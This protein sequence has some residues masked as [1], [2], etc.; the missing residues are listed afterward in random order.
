MSTIAGNTKH[1]LR[2]VPPTYLQI[3]KSEVCLRKAPWGTHDPSLPEIPSLHIR[4]YI[5]TYTHIHIHVPVCLYDFS[6]SIISFLY[7][8]YIMNLSEPQMQS[9]RPH[10]LW[11]RFR[12]QVRM[13]G[14]GLASSWVPCLDLVLGFRFNLKV[15]V[16]AGFNGV[17]SGHLT[18][19][20]LILY[21]LSLTMCIRLRLQALTQVQ[22]SIRGLGSGL[23]LLR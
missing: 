3:E 19:Y 20:P 22:V 6:L 21:I 17:E 15:Q 10:R 2:F 5:H 14:L 18:Y 4:T 13:T 12:F 7:I 16:R 23:V 9:R 11:L 1:I 8:I